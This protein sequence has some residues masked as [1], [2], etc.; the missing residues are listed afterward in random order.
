MY[1]VNFD[2]LFEWSEN[3]RGGFGSLT[4]KQREGRED[5]RIDLCDI[6]FKGAVVSER[7]RLE[8]KDPRP[9][10]VVC[11][12]WA[13]LSL[14]GPRW[15]ASKGDVGPSGQEAAKESSGYEDQTVGRTPLKAAA[16]TV[17]QVWVSLLDTGDNT[18]SCLLAP[19]RIPCWCVSACKSVCPLC[20]N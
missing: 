15:Q 20:P 12:L 6:G 19:K 4:R 18:R 13:R 7:H 5:E 11:A 1:T 16:A 10:C 14:G 3:N 9:R 17:L 8:Q 2:L